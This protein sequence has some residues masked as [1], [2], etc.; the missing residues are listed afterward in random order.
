MLPI[1]RD[2]KRSFYI[3]LSLPATAMGFALSVQIS[4]LS[5]ILTTQYGLDIHDVGLV[6]AAGPIAGILGQVIIGVV[7]DKTWF[8]GGRR[9][10]YI[11]IGGVLAS[12]MLLALPNIDV[13]SGGL[14]LEGILGVALI[15]ALTLDL[16]IN[17]S[18]N[19]TRAIIA[20]VTPEGIE[21]TRGYTWMQTISGSFGVLAYA[22][23][24]IWNNYVL[25]YAGVVLV[26]VFSIL[27]PL[28]V[29]EPEELG[30]AEA[31]QAAGGWREILFSIRPLWGFLVYDLYA[32]TLRLA[33]IEVD[34]YYAEIVCLLLTAWLVGSTLL[35]RES[36]DGATDHIGF[37]KVLAAHS[38]SWVGVQTMFIYTLAYVQ[39]KMP[40]LSD[41]DAGR[42]I[43]ISFL[44]L[45]AVA[46]ILPAFVLEP[47]TERIGR[48]RTHM[49]CVAIMAL[50]YLGI[51]LFGH[52]AT[53][54]YLLMA[55]CG[56]GWAAIVSLPFAI[57]SQKVEQS[58]MGLYMGLFNLSVV[59]PQLL[60]SLAVGLAV[61]R[62]E[63][64]N[65]IFVIC[66]AS[67]AISAVAWSLVREGEGTTRIAPGGGH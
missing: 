42:V 18:F 33:H 46:A 39:Q 59:L 50:G 17:V 49:C 67:L 53:S 36:S 12:L 37:Q 45:N 43:S 4:A 2:L 28:F 56:V 65:L 57:M 22:I 1:Q 5:W 58:R 7:S 34:N 21:R 38:F 9:R 60:A 20:D 27:P 40:G 32:L 19:P 61:S 10:P 64:K 47:I 3:L 52:S 31:V 63:D 51:T 41:V 54:L 16:A 66:A 23:G 44:V 35:Q 14:G 6:W 11:L 13:I 26:L 48:V 55:V 25:I 8:W 29:Q 15:V 62:A 30:E 24:A